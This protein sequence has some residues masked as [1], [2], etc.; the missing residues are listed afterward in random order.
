MKTLRTI[1]MSA[2]AIA[3]AACGNKQVIRSPA[4]TLK[5]C[6]TDYVNQGRSCSDIR[7]AIF[8]DIHGK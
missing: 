4:Q 1:T 3:L 5:T 2:I 7:T 8:T 6:L